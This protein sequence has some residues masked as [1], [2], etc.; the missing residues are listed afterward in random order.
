VR[1]VALL[2]GRRGLR[3]AQLLLE[4]GH[5]AFSDDLSKKKAS[6]AKRRSFLKK[7]PTKDIKTDSLR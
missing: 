6:F 3:L 5:Q 1:D 2:R 7:S 4:G